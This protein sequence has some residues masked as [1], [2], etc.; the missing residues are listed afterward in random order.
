MGYVSSVTMTGKS[1]ADGTTDRPI[2]MQRVSNVVDGFVLRESGVAPELAQKCT[3]RTSETKS[4]KGLI[5][6]NS[7]TLWEWP[8][9]VPAAPGVVAGTVQ[10]NKAGL[11][12][13]S[14]CPANVRADIRYQLSG[15]ASNVVGSVG[16]VLV[17]DPM[18]NGNFAF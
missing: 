9:E 4:S 2:T 16:Y 3:F 14:N 5:I 11:H 18:I 8:Y 6:R 15:M 12:V 13:P 17:Y 1:R 7:Q 10:L